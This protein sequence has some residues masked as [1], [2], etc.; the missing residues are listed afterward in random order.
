MKGHQQKQY[1][2]K[3]YGKRVGRKCKEGRKEG[4]KEGTFTRAA[5]AKCMDHHPS[6]SNMTTSNQCQTTSKL[7]N[8]LASHSHV[9][10]EHDSKP[11]A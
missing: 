5:T 6:L 7:E 9:K 2:E 3:K 8:H 11:F 4:R 1:E 10:C